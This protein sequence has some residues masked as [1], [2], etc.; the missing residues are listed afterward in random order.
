MSLRR[1]LRAAADVAEVDLLA[2]EVLDPGDARPGKHVHLLVVEPRHVG[3]PGVDVGA[4]LAR[5]LQVA[6]DVGLRDAEIDAAQMQDVH[7]VLVAALA[8][9]RQHAQLVAVV[10]HG[11][12]VV[13]EIEIGAVRIARH[14]R[15]RVL[16]ELVGER[17][18]AGDGR[19]RRRCGTLGGWHGRLRGRSEQL[20]RDAR[21]ERQQRRECHRGDPANRTHFNPSLD[22]ATDYLGIRRACGSSAPP[23]A[24]PRSARTEASTEGARRNPISLIRRQILASMDRHRRKAV[25]VL[26]RPG[27]KG[28]KRAP[29]RPG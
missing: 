26:T 6:H 2:A 18:V 5:L 1:E 24:P 12:H 19:R 28:Q 4:E 11:R 10:E 25:R 14:H 13:G 22:T 9:H 21:G 17:C 15:H 20:G 7:H 27:A 23:R 16:V 29:R 3:E 8:D